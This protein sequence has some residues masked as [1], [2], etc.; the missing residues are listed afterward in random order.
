[1]VFFIRKTINERTAFEN[2][3]NIEKQENIIK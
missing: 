2:T 3:E 1:M